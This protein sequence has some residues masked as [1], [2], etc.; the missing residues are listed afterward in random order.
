MSK[1]RTFSISPSKVAGTLDSARFLSLG[2]KMQ[3]FALLP[4][5]PRIANIRSTNL[6]RG[7]RGR[8][9]AVA[10]GKSQLSIISSPTRESDGAASWSA[11]REGMFNVPPPPNPQRRVHACVT[12]A[13]VRCELQRPWKTELVMV[14]L[15]LKPGNSRLRVQWLT[16]AQASSVLSCRPTLQR[17]GQ[18][19]EHVANPDVFS[20]AARRALPLQWSRH[21][22]CTRAAFAIWTGAAASAPERGE[23]DPRVGKRTKMKEGGEWAR[24]R[25]RYTYSKGRQQLLATMLLEGSEGR[26]GSMRMDSSGR[27]GGGAGGLSDALQGRDGVMVR[28]LA[29]YQGETDF[30]MWESCRTMLLVG[31]FSRRSPVPTSPPPYIPALLHTHLASPT[32]AL[33]TLMLGA[34]LVLLPTRYV[35]FLSLSF[36]TYRGGAVGWRATDLG[37]GRLWIRIPGKAWVFIYEIANDRNPLHRPVKGDNTVDIEQR[38]PYAVSLVGPLERRPLKMVCLAVACNVALSSVECAPGRCK[39]QHAARAGQKVVPFRRED[40]L[41]RARVSSGKSRQRVATNGAARQATSSPRG[42]NIAPGSFIVQ[43]TIVCRK[44]FCQFYRMSGHKSQQCLCKAPSSKGVNQRGRGEHFNGEEI[45]PDVRP[46]TIEVMR[47][48]INIGVALTASGTNRDRV[49]RDGY[50][51]K[52]PTHDTQD[53]PSITPRENRRIIRLGRSTSADTTA[54]I[55]RAVLPTLQHHVR[56]SGCTEQDC[57]RADRHDCLQ[58]VDDCNGVDVVVYHGVLQNCSSAQHVSA[59]KNLG[60]RAL[61]DSILVCAETARRTT[62]WDNSPLSFP[63]A[64]LPSD[65]LRAPLCSTLT[66]QDERALYGAGAA[67]D[68]S[69]HDGLDLHSRKLVVTNVDSAIEFPP[70]FEM[71]VGMRGRSVRRVLFA[72]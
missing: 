15:G 31:G 42:N 52:A 57:M 45:G 19:K 58:D 59:H 41:R 53:P 40:E 43:V 34:R 32:S 27:G 20:L 51:R 36:P 7:G 63:T 14:E 29:S 4:G 24:D 56:D 66:S 37:F 68:L 28:L 10:L 49:K 17:D 39:D 3:Y 23:G 38:I 16:N 46:A 65:V 12:G 70:T 8:G 69:D 60:R 26:V 25:S 2:H 61:F 47:C 1:G 6:N 67:F 55:Q 48:N 22:T 5:P 30:R 21:V 18:K 64:S 71:H 33:K 11:W 44:K 13:R 50:K 9:R 54:D 62:G 35:I 72:R